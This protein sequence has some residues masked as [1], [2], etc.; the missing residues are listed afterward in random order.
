MISCDLRLLKTTN[1]LQISNCFY[2]WLTPSISLQTCDTSNNLQRKKSP[3]HDALFNRKD[4][5]M[6]KAALRGEV[7][8]TIS[9]S[10]PWFI[11]LTS[12]V[13]ILPLQQLQRKRKR[14]HFI[15]Y[16]SNRRFTHWSFLMVEVVDSVWSANM[17]QLSSRARTWKDSVLRLLEQ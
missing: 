15:Y 7:I 13:F 9:S 4:D 6:R 10:R 12:L 5:Y 1:I 3:S 16:I 8:F 14:G 2:L 11:I 17:L